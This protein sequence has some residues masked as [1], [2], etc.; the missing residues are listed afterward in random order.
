MVDPSIKLSEQEIVDEVSQILAKNYGASACRSIGKGAYGNVL[1]F[2]HF[3][4]DTVICK[5]IYRQSRK[6]N[7]VPKEKIDEEINQEVTAM[8]ALEG[9]P[10]IVDLYPIINTP[11]NEQYV[12]KTRRFYLIFLKHYNAGA[13]GDNVLL[14][15]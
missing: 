5:V 7:G 1:L 3:N 9:C 4:K 8:R 13:L 2:K 6:Y 12:V 10:Y 14:K 11:G 15:L